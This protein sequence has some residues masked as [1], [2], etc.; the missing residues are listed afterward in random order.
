MFGVV[1]DIMVFLVIV[2][3]IVAFHKEKQYEAIRIRGR[4]HFRQ[5][6]RMP[7]QYNKKGVGLL[8][9]IALQHGTMAYELGKSGQ[10]LADMSRY[11][12]EDEKVSLMQQVGQAAQSEEEEDSHESQ[13]DDGDGNPGRVLDIHTFCQGGGYSHFK[14]NGEGELVDMIA[15]INNWVPSDVVAY[16]EVHHPPVQLLTSPRCRVYVLEMRA[17][18]ALRLTSDEILCLYNIEF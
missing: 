4:L 15:E 5:E 18:A 8:V 12:Y 16:H 1:I 13:E 2:I 14:W 17:D 10:K 6:R 3:L 9:L 11:D 7:P